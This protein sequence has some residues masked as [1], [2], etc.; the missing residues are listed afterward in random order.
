VDT[1]DTRTPSRIGHIISTSDLRARPSGSPEEVDLPWAT[2]AVA[3]AF[4]TA[5]SHRV[6]TPSA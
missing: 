5:T 3:L 4:T 1:W 2:R 6:L